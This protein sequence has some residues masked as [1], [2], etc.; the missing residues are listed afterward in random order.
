[1]GVGVGRGDSRLGWESGGGGMGFGGL[2]LA[3]VANVA[4]PVLWAYSRA[5]SRATWTVEEFVS[6][7]PSIDAH[8]SSCI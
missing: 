7:W 2:G 4:L 5:C 3:M 1:M 8:L 6:D